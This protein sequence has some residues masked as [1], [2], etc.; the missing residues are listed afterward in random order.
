MAIG[1]RGVITFTTRDR[2]VHHGWITSAAPGAALD[3]RMRIVANV[4]WRFARAIRFTTTAGL[5]Q[6]LLLYDA[7]LR[8]NSDIRGAQTHVHESGGCQPAVVCKTY[9]VPRESSAVQQLAER[10]LKPANRQPA[11]VRESHPQHRAFLVERGCSHAT[12]S[13]RPRSCVGVRMSA[14]EIAI[15]AMHKRTSAGAAN[16]QPAVIR[17]SRRQHRAFLAEG[18][19]SHATG[20]L[21]P[22]LLVVLRCGHL[23]AKL[24]LVRYTNA[25]FPGAAGVSPPWVGNRTCNGDRF[26]WGDYVD[27]ARS[28]GTP[29][30]AYAN[31]SRRRFWWTHANRRKCAA[32]F[33]TGDSFHHHGWLTLIAPGARRRSAEK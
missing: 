10:L 26:S 11:V 18:G 24:R 29:R 9:L 33:C 5:R 23:P 2:I 28:D 25:R 22:P 14:G 19:C 21:R 16:R 12:G 17:E 3:G 27:H 4:R 32:P 31:R 30:L 20:G 6:P 15:F 1:F 7:G 13:L 8:K